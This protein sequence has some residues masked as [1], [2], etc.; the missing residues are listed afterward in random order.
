MPVGAGVVGDSGHAL[1]VGLV[2]DLVNEGIGDT[3]QTEAAAEEGC[4]W[5]HVLQ[6]FGGRGIDLVDL[7]AEKGG[8]E[9]A[10]EEGCGLCCQYYWRRCWR[11]GSLRL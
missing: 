10:R 6:G 1:D 8:G 7:G 9:G 4:V 11:A 2:D 3:A 5:L